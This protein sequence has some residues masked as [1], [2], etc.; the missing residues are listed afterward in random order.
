MKLVAEKMARAAFYSQL[1]VIV[2][3]AGAHIEPTAAAA[4]LSTME[5]VY[6][7]F[8]LASSNSLCLKRIRYLHADETEASRLTSAQHAF[9][10]TLRLLRL[11]HGGAYS[12]QVLNPWSYPACFTCPRR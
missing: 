9:P 8:T 12:W 1:R 3:G 7:Q 5:V 11:L 2:I 4:H 6:R 10:Y